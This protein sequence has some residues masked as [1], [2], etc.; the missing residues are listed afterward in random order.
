MRFRTQP[1]VSSQLCIVGRKNFLIASSNIYTYLY[2][3]FE[4][5]SYLW[6]WKYFF[7]WFIESI[8]SASQSIH[9]CWENKIKAITTG[10]RSNY[11]TMSFECIRLESWNNRLNKNPVYIKNDKTS[12]NETV[13]T[14]AAWTVPR[15]LILHD[16]LCVLSKMKKV[17]R[18]SNVSA[19]S[20]SPMGNFRMPIRL[21]D[22]FP[23]RNQTADTC[24]EVE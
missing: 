18:S 1:S 23:T 24:F 17:T 22:A 15:V 12:S 11:P 19:R 8:S 9:D 5:E 14:Y 13:E 16:D 10:A 4:R 20:S 3:S 6:T 21:Y 2:V 7:K